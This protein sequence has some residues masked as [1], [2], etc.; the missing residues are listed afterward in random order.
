[1]QQ[2]IQK[3]QRLIEE[4]EGGYNLSFYDYT[5]ALEMRDLLEEIGTA[6]PPRLQREI[7]SVIEPLD[8]RFMQA[9]VQS[10]EPV[11]SRLAEGSREWWFRIPSAA[12]SEFLRTLIDE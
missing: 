6:V 10:A 8:N 5:H 7:A 2:L 9:T 3:W 1:L 11:D 4:V 12:G